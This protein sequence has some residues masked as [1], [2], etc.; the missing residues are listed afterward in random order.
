MKFIFTLPGHR[1]VFGPRRDEFVF[2]EAYGAYVFN[3]KPVYPAQ[4]NSTFKHV[5]ERYRE[6]EP[7]VIFYDDPPATPEE[8]VSDA[9]ATLRHFAPDALK[10]AKGPKPKAAQP[11]LAA[12]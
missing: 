1:V 11:E 10:P 4:F 7:S 8:L 3:G 6:Q 5:F 2:V 12:T 9:I